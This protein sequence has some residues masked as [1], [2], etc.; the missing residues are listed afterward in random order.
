MGQIISL[1]NQKGGVGK[2][3]SSVNLASALALRAYKTLVIDMDPQGNASRALNVSS[4]YPTICQVLYDKVPIQKAIQKTDLDSL[5]LISGDKEL[6][7]LSAELFNQ[8][9]WEFFLKKRLKVLE[10]DFDYIFID[11]PPSLGPLTINV[12]AASHCFVV[13]L[14]CEYYALEG[15]S[16]LI[17]LVRRVKAR[18]NP[19]LKFQGILLTMFDV[20]NRL[21]RQIETEVREHFEDKV[22]QTIVPRNV[23]L[24]EAPGFGQSIFQYDP[25]SPGA[26]SYYDLSA[27][28]AQLAAF[29]KNQALKGR[30]ENQKHEKHFSHPE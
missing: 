12:L 5:F 9:G 24:S 21:S 4:E 22:F 3:T 14:Q 28:F 17:S 18:L 1:V 11:C 23:R 7:G 20:R 16:Q 6:S 8:A 15:L 27:E 2:T 26:R 13:P 25:R 29:N 19:E 30:K 10:K